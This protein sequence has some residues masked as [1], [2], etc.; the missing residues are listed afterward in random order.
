MV[1][2]I[3]GGTLLFALGL[4]LTFVAQ[5]MLSNA[6]KSPDLVEQ[7][8]EIEDALRQAAGLKAKMTKFQ[9]DMA[10]SVDDIDR[11]R[12][13]IK[14]HETRISRISRNYRI[15]IELGSPNP[16][17]KRFDG[18]VFNRNA[19]ATFAAVGGTA[20]PTF[21]A[22]EVQ[23]I[24]W[25]ENLNSARDLFEKTYPVK[26]GYNLTFHGEIFGGRT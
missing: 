13:Q 3:I 18:S 25:A 9:A 1:E 6:L 22:R 15:V 23:I 8:A 14:S 7:R 10:E 17:Y 19:N 26:D 21:F 4:V 11:L 16:K 24:I 20:V 5:S 2:A 12:N